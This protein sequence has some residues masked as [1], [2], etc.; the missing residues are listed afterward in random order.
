MRGS[1]NGT[2]VLEIEVTTT[3]ED[4]SLAR[5]VKIVEAEQSRKGNAQRLA[6]RIAQALVPGIMI[7]A[8]MIA[9]AGSLLDAPHTWIARALVVLVAA[10]P[11]ALAIAAVVGIPQAAGHLT[12][13]AIAAAAGLALQMLVL[14][15]ALEMLALRR[16]THTAFGTLMALEPA[17]V[18]VLGL[19]VLGQSMTPIQLTGHPRRPGRSICSTWRKR[20]EDRPAESAEEIRAGST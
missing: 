2:G 6:D 10:S 7:L 13:G 18:V 16:M 11:C 17:I 19:L 9:V 3:A 15:F 14:P 4:N 12:A 20:S 1:I 5:T 8:T